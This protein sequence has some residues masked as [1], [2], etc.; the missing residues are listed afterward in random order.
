MID[1]AR[2]LPVLRVAESPDDTA[3]LRAFTS[4]G[5]SVVA[6]SFNEAYTISYVVEEAG[7]L[8]FVR[9]RDVESDIDRLHAVALANLRT[10][11]AAALRLAP[12]DGHLDIV[13]DGK[14]DASLVLLEEL[15]D[16]DGL[17]ARAVASP[18]V[19]AIESSESISVASA[20]SPD[21]LRHLRSLR[22]PML[23]VRRTGEWGVFA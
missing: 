13:L 19:A 9:W 21:G 2:A 20:S 17:V 4:E 18:I 16:G 11:A 12:R 14:V 7:A 6:R 22:V 8:A 10:R 5:D 23:L 1:V 3:P 15:W